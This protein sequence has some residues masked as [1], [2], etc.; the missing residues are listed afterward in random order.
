MI[1]FESPAVDVI[2]VYRSKG[3]SLEEVADKVDVWRDPAKVTVVCGDMNVCLKK[4]A[5]NKLTVELESMGFGQLNEEATHV[6]GGHIDHMYVTK[7]AAGKT[8][9]ER[10]TPFYSDHDALCLTFAG[11][12]GH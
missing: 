5:K 4:E 2:V 9:L 12:N 11:E 7:E 8:S 10:Y 3:Q 6:A 1:M